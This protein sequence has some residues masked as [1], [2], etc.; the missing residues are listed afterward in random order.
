[1]L[2]HS[3]L[4]RHSPSTFTMNWVL[5]NEPTLLPF[6]HFPCWKMT[7]LEVILPKET[8]RDHSETLWMFSWV[9]DLEI[10]LVV[11]NHIMKCSGY[12]Y[13]YIHIHMECQKS[14]LV[15]VWVIYGISP[16]R[17][18]EPPLTGFMA[19]RFTPSL[20][21]SDSRCASQ[22]SSMLL[23]RSGCFKLI[24]FSQNG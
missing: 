3:L 1:M 23:L 9:N 14:L 24:K 7:H 16:G 2:P 22:T 6:S 8:S 17:M 5:S 19:Q 12:I 13:I 20:V 10:D 4:Y 11:K 15:P 18:Y 21:S